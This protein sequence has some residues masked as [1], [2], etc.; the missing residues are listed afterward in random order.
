MFRFFEKKD[1]Q[2]QED[3]MNEL[4]WDPSISAESIKATVKDGV[5]TLKGSVPHYFEKTC[6]ELAAQRVSGVRAIADELE[7]KL[8]TDYQK[9]DEQ[10]AKAAVDA[11][12]WN[13]S[14]P[15]NVQVT[16][17]KGWVTL[18]G[19]VE[20]DFQ[21]NAARSAVAPLLGV[22]GVTNNLFIKSKVQPS[23]VKKRIQDA[24]KRSAENDARDINITVE[25]NQV[26]LSGHV[27]SLAEIEDARF[28]AWS[29]PGVMTVRNN[30][31]LAA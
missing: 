15:G 19:D 4:N 7:V 13:Y 29:A 1:T 21:R 16:V 25:G 27:H 11:L 24:L 14:V 31:K 18:N 22:C 26:T 12:E 20:W 10:I 30:L 3:V 17:E 23:D 5:V 6:A 2:I 9:S 28:A 8:L